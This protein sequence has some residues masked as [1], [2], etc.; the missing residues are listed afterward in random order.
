M[1]LW[2]PSGD[3]GSAVMGVAIVSLLI[4]SI[5]ATIGAIAWR[6]Y[7]L[8]RKNLDD[9]HKVL[10]EMHAKKRAERLDAEGKSKFVK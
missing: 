10:V 5:L 1:S 9:M 3:Y 4:P 2:V 7:P 6:W 8:D